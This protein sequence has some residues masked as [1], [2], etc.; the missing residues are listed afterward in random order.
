[1][2]RLPV[3]K[4]T[5]G[6][7]D[8]ACDSPGERLE[9]VEEVLRARAWVLDRMRSSDSKQPRPPTNASRLASVMLTVSCSISPI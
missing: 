6:C 4:S 1:M 9:R 5:N 3:R 8:R 2:K 7:A